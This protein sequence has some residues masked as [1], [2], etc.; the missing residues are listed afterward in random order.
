MT[1][2]N[3]L[4]AWGALAFTIPVAIHL[5]FRSRHRSVD[6][7]AMHLL[8]DVWQVNHRRVRLL[9]VW[10][11]LLRCLI[12]VLLAFCL[13]RP[14]LTGVL[15]SANAAR[16]VIVVVDDSLSMSARYRDGQE[17]IE[18]A[19]QMLAAV[20]DSLGNRDEVMILR[21]SQLDTVPV[22]SGV[23][24]AARELREITANAGPVSLAELVRG[25]LAAAESVPHFQPEVLVVTD[26]LGA[27]VDNETTRALAS[28]VE[29]GDAS[30]RVPVRLLHVC[31]DETPPANLSVEA[32]DVRDP[33]VITG[34]PIQVSAL[35]RNGSNQPVSGVTVRWHA[36]RELFDEQSI[37][38]PP[39]SQRLVTT[40]H[41]FHAEGSKSIAVSIDESDSLA[42]DN[43][44]AVRLDVRDEVVVLLVDGQ[45]DP[46]AWQSET[47]FLAAALSPFTFSGD[48]ET[49]AIRA[50]VT[51]HP[52]T[53]AALARA[54]PDV[55]VLANVAQPSDAEKMLVVD[56]V[57]SGGSLV[58]FDGS[59]IDPRAYNGVWRGSEG[60]IALPAELGGLV[61]SEPGKEPSLIGGKLDIGPWRGL[62]DADPGWLDDVDLSGFR[63]LSPRP[64]VARSDSVILRTADGE[65]LVVRAP[66]GAGQIV[67]WA[68][69]CDTGWSNLP[70]R[71]A[72]VPMMQQLMLALA[73]AETSIR[74]TGIAGHESDLTPAP[75]DRISAIAKVLDA[76]I[77]TSADQW[78][79]DQH[80]E[81]R[82]RELWPYLL[83][84]LVAVMIAEIWLQQR[85][86]GRVANS[87]RRPHRL[88]RVAA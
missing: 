34:R 10:L 85:L 67:Q 33:A 45:P 40:K 28:F 71:P 58:L 35:L 49:G 53:A 44:R 50:V 74:D 29:S 81:R 56:H 18:R 8:S 75:T 80:R 25:G 16:L 15:A 5:L 83:L 63:Q 7:G 20:F 36:D 19:K 23:A 57:L 69:P 55:L 2:L 1:L 41:R 78:I 88:P 6:W 3:S 14:V 87:R 4:L 12:P 62:A 32:I 21:G 84:L 76:E 86:R 66:Q 11:L 79:L 73:G 72:F 31:A 51:A 60:E 64:S 9:Q 39:R 24:G 61:V 47:D 70:L 59:A 48:E 54:E 82:G 26:F 46:I 38:I 13:A 43:R 27:S 65:P 22:V 30:R 77:Y 37:D 68:I 17:G 42:A 52:L